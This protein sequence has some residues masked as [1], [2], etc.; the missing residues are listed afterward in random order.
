M[1]EDIFE[2]LEKAYPRGFV[3]YW[4]DSEGSVRQSGFNMDKSNFLTAFHHLGL[5]LSCLTKE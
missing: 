1:R 2:E 5:A 3:F 4:L